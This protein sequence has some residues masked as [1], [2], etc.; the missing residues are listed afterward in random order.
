[1]DT[2]HPIQFTGIVV[3][4]N[5]ERR[6]RECLNSLVFCE[7]LLVIDLGS[8]DRSI[9]IA[10]EC[11]AE[12][13]QRERVAVVEEVRKEAISYADNDWVIF[14]DPDEVFPDGIVDDLRSLIK[15][16]PHLGVIRIP[17]QFYFRGEP[18]Y[19]TRWGKQKSKGVVRHKQRNR[20]VPHVHRGIRL[21]DG[22]T[23]AT[24]PRE[25][26]LFIKHY[27]VDSYRQMFEKHWRYIKKE[28]NA[29]YNSGERFGWKRWGKETWRALKRNLI[30]YKGLKGGLTG[31]FLSLFYAWYINMSLLSLWL[32]QKRV[33]CA[34]QQRTGGDK[35]CP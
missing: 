25:P 4:Y 18:L 15:E 10:R 5:E 19:V 11:G 7:Q 31:I 27:W 20:F 32:Y 17:W 22:F 9:E 1:M 21:L 6:L 13:V 29:R 14:L 35:R 26:N 33:A 23:S 30:N 28:G 2:E 12:V 8:E 34:P 24:I 16:D 3:T